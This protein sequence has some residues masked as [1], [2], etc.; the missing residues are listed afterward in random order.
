MSRRVAVLLIATLSIAGLSRL[1]VSLRADTI[2]L[3]DGTHIADCQITRTTDTMVFLRSPAGDMGVP[4][5]K[6]ERIERE[7]TP[8]DDFR[9]KLARLK[10]D[11]IRGMYRLANLCRYQEGLRKESDELAAKI[12][13]LDSDHTGARKL[14]GHIPVGDRWYVPR[15][16]SVQLNVQSA[17]G[18]T[19]EE[20][21]SVVSTFLASRKDVKVVASLEGVKPLDAVVLDL[22]VDVSQQ[23][24]TVFYGRQ[25]AEGFLG[26]NVG[27]R[28]RSEWAGKRAPTTSIAGEYPRTAANAASIATKTA[29]SRNHA[30][31]HR[32]IDEVL[33]TRAKGIHTVLSEKLKAERSAPKKPTKPDTSNDKP[34]KGRTRKDD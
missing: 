18:T 28:A 20:L 17:R 29:I 11:D 31:L 24:G 15:P 32:F 19:P 12:F 3:T 21:A 8:Y 30:S 2:H 23:A 14:L 9:D 22:S 25:I 7:R 10:P 1:S 34:T 26:A 13:E 4:V 33:A 5:S 27:L 16:L 6:I